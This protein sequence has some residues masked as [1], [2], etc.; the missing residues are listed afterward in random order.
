MTVIAV[1]PAAGLMI[2]LGKLVQMAGGDLSLVMT[3]GST[4][5]NIGWAV[6]NSLDILFA[7]AIGGSWAKEGAGGLLPQ[8]LHLYLLLDYRFDLRGDFRDAK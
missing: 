4:M 1:M 8:L 2:S 7:V 3:I 5:E 6:I